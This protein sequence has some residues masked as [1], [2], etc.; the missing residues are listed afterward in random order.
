MDRAVDALKDAVQSLP[1]GDAL[2]S[3]ISAAAVR[4]LMEPTP[5]EKPDMRYLLSA[6][7]GYALRLLPFISTE[8]LAALKE[9][10]LSYYPKKKNRL[11]NQENLL[12]EIKKLIG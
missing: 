5:K 3:E 10:Y 11:P 8:E 12:N 1:E 7:D 6:D 2:R 4:L 9:E